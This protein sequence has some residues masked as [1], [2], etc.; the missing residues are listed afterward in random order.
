M[1]FTSCRREIM[2]VKS[3][4]R[5]TQSDINVF[6]KTF[7]DVQGLVGI[8]EKNEEYAKDDPTIFA[9][10]KQ[11]TLINN[12]AYLYDIIN[13]GNKTVT[14]SNVYYDTITNSYYLQDKIFTKIKDLSLIHI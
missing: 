5:R 10:L 7:R 4:I 14:R 13:G 8:K 6:T 12:Y 1:L 11:K 3:S 9:P 2:N